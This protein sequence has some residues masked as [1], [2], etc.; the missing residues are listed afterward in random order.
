MDRVKPV[1]RL[2]AAYDD[3]EGVTAAVQ[4][5]LVERI[6]RELGGDIPLDAFRHEARW[7]DILSRIEMHLVATRDVEF[8]ISGRSFRFT[9]G[10]SIHTENSHKYGQR[11]GRAAAARRR[12]DAVAEWTDRGR[13]FR[14]VLAMA[15]PE[16]FRPLI[17]PPMTAPLSA[18][19]ALRPRRYRQSAARILS[20]DHHHPGDPELAVA[21]NVLNSS[22]TGVRAFVIALD[23]L[24]APLYR[25]IRRMLPDFGGIDFSPLVVLILI[26]V[27]KKLLAGV[28][29]QITTASD[30]G[31]ADRRQGRRAGPSRS[32]RR[33]SRQFPRTHR[34]GA[35]PRG[36]PGRRGSAASAVYVRSK[37]NATPKR[38][39]QASSTACPPR[40]ARTSWSQLIDR[41]NAD[42]AVDGIL[43]QLPLPP[44]STNG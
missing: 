34:P 24:T 11:G 18:R 10:S 29:A 35:R 41:L 21:F 13:R 28:V 33:A 44:R 1:D 25:P 15:E 31:A 7:N 43:V 2:I 23:R 26:Q 4:P 20:L 9:A 37:V 6:N 27:I 42:P 8:T 40:P 16:P 5:Q 14:R 3:P 32:D 22:S 19:H 39:W 38:G 12:L 30:D 36:R 17:A